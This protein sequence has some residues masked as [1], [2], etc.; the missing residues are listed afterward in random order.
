[1]GK[2]SDGDTGEKSIIRAREDAVDVMTEIKSVLI[3]MTRK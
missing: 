1:M 3:T 2:W